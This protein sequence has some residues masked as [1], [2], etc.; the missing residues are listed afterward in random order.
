MPAELGIDHAEIHHWGG[1][2]GDLLAQILQHVLFNL[3]ELREVPGENHSISVQHPALS[4]EN[5]SMLGV[6]SM[7]FI[8][9]SLIFI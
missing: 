2:A 4:V 7:S 1:H 5:R 9:K 6:K 8:V 3:N